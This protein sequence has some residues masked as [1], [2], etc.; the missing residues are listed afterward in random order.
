M[1]LSIFRFVLISGLFFGAAAAHAFERSDGVRVQC[2]ITLNGQPHVVKEVWL[3]SGDAGQ[4]HP[5]LGGAAAVMRA[6]ADGKPVIFFDNVVFK[7]MLARDPHMSDFIFYHE[8]GHAQE[9]NLDEIEANCYAVLAMQELGLMTD[10]KLAAL[11]GTHGKML[12]LPSRYGGSGQ[13][14]W[15]RT[16]ACVRNKTEKP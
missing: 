2:E 15:D 5:E 4:R 1:R 7:G 10:A 16:M 12:R 13:V 8:C 11:A 6:D 3:G 9:Q 14:F